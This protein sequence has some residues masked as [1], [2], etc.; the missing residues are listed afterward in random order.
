MN[1]SFTSYNA[2]I[3]RSVL[4]HTVHTQFADRLTG[5]LPARPQTAVEDFAMAM[6]PTQTSAPPTTWP[7]ELHTERQ[8]VNST[9]KLHLS[10]SLVR[11]SFEASNL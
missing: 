6:L 1:K 8:R 4:S 9:F 5:D 10:F 3:G 7:P 11:F 2:K